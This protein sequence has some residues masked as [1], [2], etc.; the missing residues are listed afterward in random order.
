MMIIQKSQT[1]PIRRRCARRWSPGLITLRETGTL[2]RMFAIAEYLRL[3]MSHRKRVACPQ[4][5][6][7]WRRRAN[8]TTH[9][10]VGRA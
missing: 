2:T 9:H 7:F 8:Q 4:M 10:Q 5:L 1:T 6:Q 3:A